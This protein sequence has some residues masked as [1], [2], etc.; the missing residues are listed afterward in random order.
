MRFLKLDL[1]GAPAVALSLHRRMTVVRAGDEEERRRLAEALAGLAEGVVWA[2]DDE[3]PSEEQVPIAD[4]AVLGLP[5]DVA[6]AMLLRTNDIP[7]ASAAPKPFQPEP[8]QPDP[9]SVAALAAAAEAENNACQ[10]LEARRAQLLARR[11]PDAETSAQTAVARALTELR[12]AEAYAA[13]AADDAWQIRAEWETLATSLVTSGPSDEAVEAIE[14]A[15]AALAERREEL[16][17]ARQAVGHGHMTS[18]DAAV[19]GH[20]HTEVTNA[21][22]RADRP[23]PG[24]AA[25]RRLADAEA[26]E[27]KFLHERGFSSYSAYLLDTAV[28]PMDPEPL[29]RLRD[30]ERAVAEAEVAWQ[31]VQPSADEL[32]LQQSLQRQATRLR[33]RAAALLGLDPGNAVAERLADWPESC[34]RLNE[35]RADLHGVLLAAGVE[36]DPDPA[37]TAETWL[38]ARRA[39]AAEHAALEAELSDVEAE[40][41]ALQRAAAARAVKAEAESAA[42]ATVV[43]ESEGEALDAYLFARLA[44]HRDV[45]AIG[46]LPL[47]LEDAFVDLALP[48]RLAGLA[49]L[50]EMSATVQV[51]YVSTDPGVLAWASTMRSDDV[52]VKRPEPVV[53]SVPAPP[54][55][56]AVP[57]LPVT[58]VAPT[59]VPPPV[60]PVTETPVAP[61]TESP[62]PPAPPAP[63]E[64]VYGPRCNECRHDLAIG[65]CDRCRNSFCGTH[66]VRMKRASRPPL[67]LACALVSAG[68]RPGRR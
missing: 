5:P 31:S 52:E 68:S 67:C 10:E 19:L 63:A 49:L 22:A 38:A 30:A 64:T 3:D 36:P 2:F 41:A 51:I 9:A 14:A 57:P 20:L 8:V 15:R 45:G 35:T 21:Q 37:G 33:E 48:A 46:S 29:K 54:A 53:P 17:A 18:E 66:L 28:R 7:A 47:V 43:D 23:F 65:H 27:E 42:P 24:Q 13:A 11:A 59:H 62:V 50:A 34:A 58:P 16:A 56:L 12:A 1:N 60:P 4:F 55:A 6:S 26:A 40:L 44:V 25:R 32:Y 39:E 61:V